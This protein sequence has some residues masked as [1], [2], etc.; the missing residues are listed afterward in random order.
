M[1]FIKNKNNIL[2]YKLRCIT[3]LTSRYSYV[4]FVY[5]EAN[6]FRKS[7]EVELDE[8]KAIL[9]CDKEE[10]AR[11]FKYFSRD[12]LKKVHKELTEKTECRY[13]YEPVKK[14][15]TVVAIRFELES[16]A[17]QIESGEDYDPDQYTIDDLQQRDED[18]E[19]ICCG[20]GGPEFADFSEEQLISLKDMGWSN[21][22][23]EDVDRHKA[24]LGDI[25][26][27]CE[28]ATAD[29]LRHKILT[30]KTR[31]PKNL[32]GYVCK[33]IANDKD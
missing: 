23:Q 24:E 27:A 33:M 16:L 22:K 13:S 29:Y 8:L 6:R 18:R 12:V 15:R 21:V 14:G 28:Y 10:Y 1:N 20:F 31:K 5:L 11:E 4:M 17:P 30:A 25:K 26:L 32:Y 9:N 3:A 7:W 19:A 2:R